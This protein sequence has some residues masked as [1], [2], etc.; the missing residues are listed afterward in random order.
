MLTH[1]HLP[2][3]ILNR[4]LENKCKQNS[5]NNFSTGKIIQLNKIGNILGKISVPY[6]DVIW[7]STIEITL[8]V[9]NFPFEIEIWNSNGIHTV[10][11]CETKC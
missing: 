1:T 7:N 4:D 9:R 5:V 8:V 11:L 6:S 3:R 10:L 2:M